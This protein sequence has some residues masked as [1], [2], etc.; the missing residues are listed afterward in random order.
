MRSISVKIMIFALLTGAAAF[1]NDKYPMPGVITDTYQIDF[2]PML[3]A[4]PG[5]TDLMV[6]IYAR[7]SQPTVGINMLLIYDPTLLMPI[8]IV[9]NMFFQS[10]VVD[11]SIP[12]RII[13]NLYTDLPPPPQ[14][15]PIEG[16]TIIAWIQCRVTTEDI[17]YDFL[18]HFI[19]FDDPL[20][21]YPDNNLF[22][23]NGNW[24]VPPALVLVQANVLIISPLYG[25]INVNGF[26][27]EIGDAITFLNY[28]MGNIQFTRRQYANSDCNRDGIQASIA[29]LVYLLGV[30]SGDT[31]SS[32]SD[33]AGAIPYSHG[34][35]VDYI[36]DNQKSGVDSYSSFAVNIECQE[37]LG[38]AYFV[39]EFDPEEVNIESVLLN[40]SARDLNLSWTADEGKLLVAVYNWNGVASLFNS[41]NLVT[42]RYSGGLS[43]GDSSFRIAR[44]EFSDEAGVAID[45][46]YHVVDIAGKVSQEIPANSGLSIAGYPNPFNGLV[47][48][49]YEL[50][51][52][53]NY[54]LVIF[55]ILGREVKTLMNGF[56][57]PGGGAII[58][59]GTDNFNGNVSSGIYFARLRG[60]T[61]SGNIKL[62]MLK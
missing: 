42:V 8:H 57:S 6:P 49:N 59:D 50:P 5:E 2:G 28:F 41:G 17:G 15:P 54:D 22:L 46:D 20:T 32:A 13:I 21:P 51:C 45:A 60:E 36:R 61:V 53:G 52:E 39:I 9:P 55:D 56:K 44:A 29:D 35:E 7:V 33:I 38:G 40:D 12:G 47:T 10:F 58:W 3:E 14:I 19:F 11:H 25:D 1:A 26:A 43:S 62:I 24:V 30:I 34:R 37:A 18:T 27:F 4:F 23:E 31:V 16:D 48:I